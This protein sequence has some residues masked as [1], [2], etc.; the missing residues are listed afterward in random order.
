MN[1]QYEQEISKYGKK[2]ALIALLFAV[3][4]IALTF[5]FWII[6][7]VFDVSGIAGLLYGI[8]LALVALSPLFLIV[9]IKRQ[10]LRSLGVH[11]TNW[12]QAVGA[13][14]F[15]VA[16]FLLLFNGLLPGL[17]AGWQFQPPLII[18]LLVGYQLIMAFWEDVIFIGYIQTRMYGLIKKDFLAVLIVG[19][20]F[21][22]IHYPTIIAANIVINGGFGFGFWISLLWQTFLLVIVYIAMNAVFRR[23]NSIIPVTL[24]HFSFNFSQLGHL[25]VDGGGDGFNNLLALGIFIFSV[26]LLTVIL[27][28]FKKRKTYTT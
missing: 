9:R 4:I 23:F 27:P 14:L 12:P 10:G 21:A 19:L 24:F 22:A 8:A 20:I 1:L 26:L 2:D 7:T 25:W 15:F 6:M 16:V 13:G 17:L 3:Y 28:N 18:A 11:F 5:A